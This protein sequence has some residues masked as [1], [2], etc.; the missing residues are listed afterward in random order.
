MAQ[1]FDKRLNLLR[2]DLEIWEITKNIWEMAQIYGTLLKYLRY[3]IS[4]LQ[5]T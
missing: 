4:M 2:N 1:V 5:R 3:G